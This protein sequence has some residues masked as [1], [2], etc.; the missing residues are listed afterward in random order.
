[1]GAISM[2]RLVERIRGEA[3]GGGHETLIAH[4][5]PR[6]STRRRGERA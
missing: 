4:V 6:G 3:A 2:Q 1:V 5:L